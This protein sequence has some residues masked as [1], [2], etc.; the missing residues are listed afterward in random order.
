MQYATHLQYIT[1]YPGAYVLNPPG[2]EVGPG[3]VTTWGKATANEVDAY[4]LQWNWASKS[5]KHI[6]FDWT[7]PA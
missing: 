1:A 7:G 4:G 3:Q 5:S 6:P 2:S